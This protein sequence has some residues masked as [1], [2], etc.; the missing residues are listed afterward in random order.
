MYEAG[1]HG[2]TIDAVENRY[3]GEETGIRQRKAELRNRL[4]P[5]SV[6][7]ERRWRLVDDGQNGS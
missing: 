1:E 7:V 5:L 4:I 2:T 3:K 6:T